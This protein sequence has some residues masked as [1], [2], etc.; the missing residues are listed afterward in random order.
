MTNMKILFTGAS[1]F[2]GFWF[3]NELALN[4]HAVFATFQSPLSE[5]S[6]LRRARIDQLIN[7]CQPYFNTSF[8]TDVF[9]KLL[10]ESDRW[11]I[12]CHHGACV[13]NYKSPDF[14]V[15]NAITNNTL[16][17]KKVFQKLKEKGCKKIILT[18]SVFEQNEGVGS[19][20]MAFSPYGLSK[21]LT[22]EIFSYYSK[23]YKIP[24]I[25]F[26]IPNPFGPFE[27]FRFTTSLI[28][29]WKEGKVAHVNAP[30]YVRD[31]IHVSLLA[32]AYAFIV[33][34]NPTLLFEKFNPS[35][36]PESQG[37]FTARFANEMRKRLMLNCEYLLHEQI[38]F[39]E[40]K[41]RI[42][43]DAIILKET[44]W[45]ESKAWDHLAHYYQTH[46]LE[47]SIVPNR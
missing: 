40:P 12:F 47:T 16:N 43:Y 44:D 38:D 25:K 28:Q 45:S 46:F 11:D 26:V 35:G 19:D 21:G 24:L 32:K 14:D 10:E 17:V 9:F 6:G 37:A 29:Q 7:L 30:L 5:Y 31:N 4:K 33:E 39:P 2:T 13:T 20:S 18:G 42:N 23:L 15:T 22:S 1:S 34:K 41:V 3:I 8:G 36:Y 27:E